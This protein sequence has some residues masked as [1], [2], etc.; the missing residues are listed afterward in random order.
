M[1][2]TALGGWPFKRESTAPRAFRT[3]AGSART[4]AASEA[5]TGKAVLLPRLLLHRPEIHG[6]IAF[7]PAGSVGR[8]MKREA[9]K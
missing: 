1:C 8:K 7:L 5:L 3:E 6:R 2:A 9:E 4:V